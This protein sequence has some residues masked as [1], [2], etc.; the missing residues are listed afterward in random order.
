METTKKNYLNWN[1]ME[2]AFMIFLLLET[3]FL[4]KALHINKWNTS[5]SRWCIYTKV[6][7]SDPED[8]FTTA[9][10]I[11]LPT[12]IPSGL[13]EK[14]QTVSTSMKQKL[15][16]PHRMYST[17]ISQAF[18]TNKTYNWISHFSFHNVSIGSSQSQTSELFTHKHTEQTTPL[19]FF[20]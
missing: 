9:G 12:I 10:A 3:F 16:P 11:K 8:V 15:R 4:L 2:K 18:I 13:A 1:C 7:K 20:A 19:L 17:F 6:W 5:A 14:E